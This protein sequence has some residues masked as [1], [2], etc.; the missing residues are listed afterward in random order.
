MVPSEGHPSDVRPRGAVRSPIEPSGGPRRHS[1]ARFEP[2]ATRDS[3]SLGV[4]ERDLPS[5]GCPTG[6]LPPAST[7]LPDPVRCQ[8]LSELAESF[9][10]QV[11]GGSNERGIR[12][13]TAREEDRNPRCRAP[14]RGSSRKDG[15]H[16]ERRR[17]ESGSLDVV[18][19][20]GQ[21]PRGMWLHRAWR[22]RGLLSE[23]RV[24]R[25]PLVRQ[26]CSRRASLH[27]DVHAGIRRVRRRRRVRGPHDG[28]RRVLARRH[29]P[30][31]EWL[32]GRHSVRTRRRVCVCFDRGR[33]DLPASLS[34]AVG[35]LLRCRAE[36]CRHVQRGRLLPRLT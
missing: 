11:V 12:P 32:F 26:R 10:W 25:G 4:E 33:P 9:W 28:G 15:T 23:Q 36:L 27:E 29:H 19:G 7:S 14:R 20:V 1:R 6:A 8:A 30:A 17:C 3:G 34:A 18:R 31:R 5:D 22:R 21:R 16:E 13:R 2:T 35:G 24:R